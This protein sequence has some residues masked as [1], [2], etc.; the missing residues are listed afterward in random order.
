MKNVNFEELAKKFENRTK[1]QE[2]EQENWAKSNGI[3]FSGKDAI[4]KAISAAKFLNEEKKTK[5]NCFRL[6]IWVTNGLKRNA[7]K[8][9]MKY[10]TFVNAILAQYA[11]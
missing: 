5:Q 8:A 2:K 6:P 1:E 9:G 10:H 4:K 7:E 3:S 11:K